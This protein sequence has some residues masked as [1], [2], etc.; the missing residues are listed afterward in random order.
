[1]SLSYVWD[2]IKYLKS[3]ILTASLTIHLDK[4]QI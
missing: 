3:K 4:I 1:M 2:L